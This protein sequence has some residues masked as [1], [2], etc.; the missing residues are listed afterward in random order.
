[1]E[2]HDPDQTLIEVK[3]KEVDKSLKERQM[4]LIFASG[5]EEIVDAD[6]PAM[7][8]RVFSVAGNFVTEGEA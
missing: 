3:T 4:R 7:Q 1:M 5:R 6:D 8:N 2:I